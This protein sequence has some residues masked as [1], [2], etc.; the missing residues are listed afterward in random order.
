MRIHGLNG[1]DVTID[2][3]LKSYGIRIGYRVIRG[4]RVSPSSER[5]LNEIAKLVEEFRKRYNSLEELRNDPTVQ[6]Y[7]KAMWRLGIDPTKI[8][9]SS[10]AL[11]R[12]VL[13]GNSLPTINNVV[14]AGNASSLTHLV[15]IGLY[16]LDTLSPPLTLTLCKN[17]CI[18]EPIGGGLRRL[19]PGTPVL[20]D[21][22]GYIVHVYPH[23]DSIKT[24]ITSSTRNVLAVSAGVTGIDDERLIQALDE[25][26][27][28]LLIDGLNIEYTTVE[29][30]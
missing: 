15:P 25:L 19:K 17:E 23:R 24:A 14:D 29:L 30:A 2:N 13:R 18:F 7:R 9:P 22:S 27:R 11:A 28:L 6:A 12:R 26:V 16:D 21:S 1:L 3:Q 8:R 5:L 10:E 20:M 4:V